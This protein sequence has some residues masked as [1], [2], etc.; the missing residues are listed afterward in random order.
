MSISDENSL[1]FVTL[2]NNKLFDTNQGN[3]N[4]FQVSGY[5]ST[6]EDFNS[7]T[8]KDKVNFILHISSSSL[9]FNFHLAEYYNTKNIKIY[10]KNDEAFTDPCFLSEEFDF[11]LTQKFRK[12]NVFQKVNYGN[13]VCKYISFDYKYMRINFLCN[14][15]S[16]V[17]QSVNL[18]YGV[19]VFDVKKE[20][21]EDADKVYHL[22]TKC[23][24]KINNIG[25]NWGFWFFLFICV[26]ELL[27]CIGIGVL[28]FGSLRKISFRKGLINDDLYKEIGT[29]KDKESNEDTN[30]NSVQLQK[31]DEKIKNKRK[32]Q[33]DYDENDNNSVIS[34]KSDMLNRNLKSCILHNFKELYPLATLCRVS[35]LSP[36]ILNS[37]FFVFNTLVLFGFNALIYYESLIEERIFDKN[38]NNFDYPMRKEFHKIILSILCQVALCII[39]KLI[40]LVTLKQRNQL[41]DLLKSCKLEKHQTINNGILTTIKDFQDQ[42]FVRRIISSS[43]M[44][45]IIIFFFYYSIA[46]CGV[47]IQ[48]QRNWFFSGIWSL[49]WNWIIFAPIYIVVISLIEHKKQDI[50]DSTV[51]YMKRLFCF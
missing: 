37:I 45:I 41:I 15:F 14:R 10:D 29:A 43:L 17:E 12:N 8:M 26:I 19:V 2:I 24:D 50:N 30:S 32:N 7:N 27:Y 25:S 16:Y 47:Y 44:A 33:I 13:D 31:Y 9:N 36:L 38:R 23:S 18:Y 22:P 5:F 46:F 49:F 48:T 11:D 20:S 51:Y 6:T 28:T 42:M 21:I 34:V 4:G 40:L 1:I 3:N 39:M 35:V